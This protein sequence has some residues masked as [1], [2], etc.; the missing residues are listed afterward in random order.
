MSFGASSQKKTHSDSRT[1]GGV[2][3]FIVGCVLVSQICFQAGALAQEKSNEQ[4]P[5]RLAK[6]AES[7][8][9]LLRSGKASPASQIEI[10]EHLGAIY[11][12]L[13]RYRDSLNVLAP[14]LHDESRSTVSNKSSNAMLAAQSWMVSGVDHLELNELPEATHALRRSLAMNP[15]SANA[16]LALG[17]ALARSGQMEDAAKQF[18]TQIKQTPSLADA[19]YK[20]GLVHSQISVKRSHAEVKP[21]DKSLLQQLE[22][23]EL[24]AKGEALNAARILFRLA[25]HS[26]RPEV[27][28]ELGTALLTLGYVKAAQ[29]H[30]RQELAN[31]SESPLAQLGFAQT[32]ALAGEWGQVGTMLERLSQSESRELMRLIELPAAG[33]V[34]QSWSTGQMKPPET[35]TNSPVGA[36]WSSWMADS[37][38]VARVSPDM[39]KDSQSC[40]ANRRNS[41]AGVW[42]TEP[43]YRELL[44]QYSSR[45]SLPIG[46]Q[47]KV[48][49]AE[50]RLG[51]Y[52]AALRSAEHLSAVDP[53]NGWASY[54]QSKAHD[55]IA[56]ECF[57]K[58][59]ELNP[60]SAR[61]HQMLAEH[62]LKLSDYPKAK[63]EFQNALRSAPNSSDVHL[64]L[65]KVFSRTS[66]WQEAEKELR[67]TLELAPKSSFAHYELGHVYVQE[68]RW[69]PAIE[70]LRQVP[71]D[72]TELLSSRLDLSKAETET[73]QGSQAVKDL[74][75]VASLDQDGELYFRLAALYRGLGDAD[76]ARQALATFKQRRAASLQTD[77]DEVGALEQEQQITRISEPNAR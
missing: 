27:H 2:W 71:E 9:N 75:S 16:R 12:L 56:E 53:L 4:S 41:P 45:K 25:R 10:R 74:L 21:G 57:L 26:A 6:A 24:L 44:L 38:I 36:L 7:Y 22:A 32:A 66:D 58:V 42:L 18:E 40:P 11:Y 31:N 72:S 67:T 73:G 50:F 5:E 3:Q 54:W 28:A 60:D 49:E 68:S 39:K 55:A 43:C 34:L 37:S 51:Q 70:Q 30:F 63:M 29:E 19:W 8:E 46:K 62:Y 61:V 65:G 1:A 59:G 20:L 64:G 23:E 77:S 17:D 48:A 76:K 69:Q 33:L 47:V 13:H 35:F 52:H 14:A 15:D